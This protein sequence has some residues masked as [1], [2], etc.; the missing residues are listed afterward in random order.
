MAAWKIAPALACGNTVV[1]KPAETTPLTALVLAEIIAEA[2][3]PPGVVNVL[4]GGP[5]IGQAIVEHDG[6]DK[7]AFTGSTEV[8]K[9]IQRTLAGTRQAAHPRARR[10][11]RQ[12]RLR[13]RPARPGGRGHRQR[14]LLQPGA[15]LLRRLAAA[16]PGVGRRRAD[17]R[18]AAAAGHAAGRRPAR[19]EHRRRRDQ[20]GGAAGPHPRARPTP[21]RP[22]APPAG[23]RRASCP[24]AASGSRR[25]CSPASRRRNRIAREEIFGPVLSVLT[26]RTPD[27]AVAKANNTPYGLSA[28][29]L[30]GEGLAHPVDGRAA[31]RRR[32]VGQHVQP[33]RPGVA[34]R[35]LQGVR[36]RPR[37][38]PARIWRRTS[39]SSER[40]SPERACVEPRSA[41]VR[42]TYKLYLGGAFPRSE[43]GRS[44]PVRPRPA[45]LLAHAAQASRKDVRDAVVAARGGLRQVVAARPRTTAARCSTGSPRCSRAARAVRREVAAAEGVRGAAAQVDAAIDRWVYY[46]GW[47]DKYAQVVGLAPTR[48]PGRTSTSRCPSRPA[49]SA[50]SRRRTPSLLGL[51]SVLA[52]VLDDRQHRGRRR[53]RRT[54]RCPPSRSPRCSPPPTCPAAWSTCSPA[55]PPSSRPGSPRTATSTR[56]TSPA[57]RPAPRADLQARRPTTSSGSS[58]PRATDWAAD[59]GL[60]RLS[61]FVETKTVW[62]P[63]GV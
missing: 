32:G 51:V 29:R 39:M 15:G 52:P 38:R 58:S 10:Q 46:A 41:A 16:R 57:P 9:I 62:H 63:I 33:V 44:Y 34:V 8:G 14:H 6:V 48:S 23:R 4:A 35:R 12:H 59:P 49:S 26:F 40:R 42:K 5:S 27:E 3:L 55:S 24:S 25:P 36:L 53:R 37:G 13:R 31:A 21:A 19:Q 56:S 60:S 28:G 43:S 17:R 22:R 45:K 47:A 18:A 1:L 54:A 30:D 2:D 61:A 20:L 50:C 7:I 11:G